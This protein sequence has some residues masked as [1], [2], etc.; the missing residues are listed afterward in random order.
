MPGFHAEGEGVLRVA[1]HRLRDDPAGTDLKFLD[2]PNDEG[3]KGVPSR[4]SSGKQKRTRKPTGPARPCTSVEGVCVVTALNEYR[5][6]AP[7]RFGNGS[8]ALQPL[9]RWAGGQ[10]LK[11]AQVQELLQRAARGIGLPP[12]R[13]RSIL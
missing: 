3:L 13:F 6:I 12:E 11:R 5:R 2:E 10:V 9:F 1:W 4:C 8:E 7:Q